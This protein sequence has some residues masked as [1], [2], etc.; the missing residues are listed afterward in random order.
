M[1]ELGKHVNLY[2]GFWFAIII[3]I[4]VPV[5]FFFIIFAVIN[6]NFDHPF[7]TTLDISLALSGT[8]GALFALSC[9]FNGSTDGLFRAFIDRIVET[10]ELFGKI[11]CKEGLKW[12]WSRFVEDGG[13]IVWGLFLFFLIYAGVAAYGYVGFISWYTSIK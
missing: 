4:L 6:H 5:S 7:K 8:A 13:F 11:F 3:L 1:E 10:R 9:Y 2:R 12:Y